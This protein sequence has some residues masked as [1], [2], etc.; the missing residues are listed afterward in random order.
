MNTYLPRSGQEAK[1]K[2]KVTEM[3]VAELAEAMNLVIL[4]GSEEGGLQR[5]VAGCYCCDLLSMTMGRAKKDD[6]YI[7]VMANVNTVSYF[8]RGS[9]R[10]MM[11]SAAPPSRIFPSSFLG[12]PP[13][14]LRWPSPTSFEALLL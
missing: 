6:A 1:K 14:K 3:T 12:S 5:E 10:G 9:H 11:W 4:T 13:L 7:T 8:P 2:E